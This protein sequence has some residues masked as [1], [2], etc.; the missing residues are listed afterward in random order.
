MG[1]GELSF[2]GSDWVVWDVLW[3]VVIPTMLIALGEAVYIYI[4][5]HF[6]K[7][8]WE[9]ILSQPLIPILVTSFVTLALLSIPSLPMELYGVSDATEQLQAYWPNLYVLIG[10]TL[11]PIYVSFRKPRSRKDKTS[12]P[13]WEQRSIAW[14]A[15]GIAA[16][17]YSLQLAA[18]S[19]LFV[20]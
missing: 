14:T 12:V 10:I 8:S 1:V 5:R 7:Q 3:F 15:W 17:E 19:G 6:L 2:Y 4:A 16:I 9:K 13:F 11:W 20:R 18:Q